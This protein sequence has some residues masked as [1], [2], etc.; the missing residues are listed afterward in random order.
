MNKIIHYKLSTTTKVLGSLYLLS[1]LPISYRLT[2]E[3]IENN[4]TN[5]RSML[6]ATGIAYGITW[7]ITNHL[8][9]FV[10]LLGNPPRQYSNITNN[11]N[12]VKL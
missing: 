7:P 1:I 3:L 12:I 6:Y 5:N 9:A 4:P 2:M 8:F 10:C 11:A